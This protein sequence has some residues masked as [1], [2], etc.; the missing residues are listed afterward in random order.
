MVLNEILEQKRKEL[1]ILKRHIPSAKIT[2]LA[3]ELKEPKRSLEKALTKSRNLHLICELKKASPSEGL[4]R[5]DFEPIALAQEFEAAGACAIS[6]LTEKHYFQG[7]PATIKQIRAFT[8]IPLLRKD[9][10]FDPYQVYET[11]LLKAD[12]FL[13][14]AMLLTDTELKIMLK[15]AQKLN[16]DTLVEIH[17]KE[18][19]QRALDAGAKIIGINN[20][21]LQTLKVDLSVSETLL[22]FIP[23]GIIAVIESG[24]ETREE[25]VR[26]QTN[27]VRC[28]LIG[29]TLMKSRNI[30]GKILELYGQSN[31][32]DDG[33]S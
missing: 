12:A 22:R 20:R 31:G 25:I 24:I 32:V 29:T 9:F 19:L 4:L 11:A 15:L 27:G 28:F 7:N 23:K 6:V 14:I 21:N 26:Y 17:T 33:K 3:E 2:R 10:I 16:L 13:L 1:E 5:K 8:T 30:K 18:E